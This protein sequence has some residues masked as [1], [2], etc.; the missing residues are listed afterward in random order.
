MV[1]EDR[2]PGQGCGWVLMIPYL[3][4][5]VGLTA[6]VFHIYTIRRGQEASRQ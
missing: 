1:I 5:T 6:I 2:L 3:D 4:A